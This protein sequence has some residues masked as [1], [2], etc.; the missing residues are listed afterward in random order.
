M[1]PSRLDARRACLGR[2]SRSPDLLETLIVVGVDCSGTIDVTV[3]VNGDRT[4]RMIA[5]QLRLGSGLTV[6][7]RD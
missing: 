7:Q 4:P 5:F 6:A 3:D 1:S 2:T